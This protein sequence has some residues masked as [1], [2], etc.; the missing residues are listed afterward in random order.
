M[1]ET[2]DTSTVFAM[3]QAAA[4]RHPDRPF[5]NVLGETA[6]IYGIAPGER[7]YADILDAANRRAEV[8]EAA[9]YGI[10]HRVGRNATCSPSR[11]CRPNTRPTPVSS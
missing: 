5:L 10:G 11:F 6:G 1:A 9:G 8:F 3:F 2:K 4:R 7:T